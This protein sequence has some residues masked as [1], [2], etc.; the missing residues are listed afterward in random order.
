MFVMKNCLPMMF[1]I[2]ALIILFGSGFAN[3]G[4]LCVFFDGFFLVRKF[5]FEDKCP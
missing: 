1:G 4:S 3:A 5:A 2:S